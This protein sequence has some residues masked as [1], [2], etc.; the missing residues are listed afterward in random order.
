MRGKGSLE[1][2]DQ[3]LSYLFQILSLHVCRVPLRM[4]DRNTGTLFS[5]MILNFHRF[6]PLL[7]R[8][9][10]YRICQ[11]HAASS[12]TN[13]HIS[14]HDKNPQQVICPHA[15]FRCMPSSID[16]RCPVSTRSSDARLGD[17][18]SEKWLV[19]SL[20]LLTPS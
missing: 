16:I 6:T 11:Q 15:L 9:S 3:M 12:G 13:V 2:E 14:T 5:R 1:V 18:T 17:Q 10:I 19:M 7:Q 4:P 8:N 20:R